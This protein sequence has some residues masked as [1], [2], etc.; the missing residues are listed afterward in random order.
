MKKTLIILFA[1]IL[2]AG[3]V[4]LVSCKKETKDPEYPQ[5]I[6]TWK[7]TTSQNIPIQ[8]QVGSSGRDLYIVGV[9]LK[10]SAAP[11]DTNTIMKY[12][13]EGLVLINGLT[14]T[15]PLEGAYPKMTQIQG[16][17]DP[18]IPALG[19]VFTGYSPNFPNEPVNGTYTASKSN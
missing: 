6:G 13:S 5:L 15:L 7:G 1:S 11:G 19:G 8:I 18:A 9:T 17:F 10:F 12:N 3:S 4:T 14:F 16:T 2:I